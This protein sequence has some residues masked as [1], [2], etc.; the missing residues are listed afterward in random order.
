MQPEAI[1][2]LPRRV[3]LRLGLAVAREDKVPDD[4][5]GAKAERVAVGG[6]HGIG[7]RHEGELGAQGLGLA[8][9]HQARHPHQSEQLQAAFTFV[10]ELGA[11]AHRLPAKFGALEFVWR[12][13]C[14]PSEQPQ[15]DHS[16]GIFDPGVLRSH[17]WIR[18][19]QGQCTAKLGGGQAQRAKEGVA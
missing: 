5:C 8:W 4:R 7:E 17:D 3:H 18:D 9:R 1:L 19:E 14:L 6:D 12:K 13:R 2:N 10:D 11:A 16:R 15:P